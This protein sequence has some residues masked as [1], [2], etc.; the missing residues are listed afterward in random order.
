MKYVLA[1][2]CWGMA[3]VCY[4]KPEW[5]SEKPNLIYGCIFICLA[6]LFSKSHEKGEK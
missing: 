4:L 1:F 2:C 3:A 6:N 5:L